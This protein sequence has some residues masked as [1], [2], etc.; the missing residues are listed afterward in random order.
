MRAIR[1]NDIS[2]I[3]PGAN[4]LAQPGLY[5]RLPDHRGDP[6]FIET[7]SRKAARARAIELLDLVGIPCSLRSAS[8][9]IPTPCPAAC[10]NA[11]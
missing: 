8:I 2:M 10:A 9:R 5:R 6:S 1:G 11:R 4:D 3:F 7:M